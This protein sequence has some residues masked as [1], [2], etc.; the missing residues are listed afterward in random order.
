MFSSQ[1]KL[2]LVNSYKPWWHSIDF[3]DGVVSNGRKSPSCHAQETRDWFP[4]DFFKDNRVLD[5]GT[6]GRGVMVVRKN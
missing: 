4:N 2:D 5:I 6:C 1:E 3:G